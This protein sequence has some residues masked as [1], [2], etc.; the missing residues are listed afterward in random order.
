MRIFDCFQCCWSVMSCNETLDNSPKEL[1]IYDA[2]SHCKLL[3]VE[4]MKHLKQNAGLLCNHLGC[5]YHSDSHEWT[6]QAGTACSSF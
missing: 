6:P 1:F 4:S 3:N 2:A 5:F